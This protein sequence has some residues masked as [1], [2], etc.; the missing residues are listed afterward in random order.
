MCPLALHNDNGGWGQDVVE[1]IAWWEKLTDGKWPMKQANIMHCIC[2]EAF[3]YESTRKEPNNMR[4]FWIANAAEIVK[5]NPKL[6]V[7]VKYLEG[8]KKRVQEYGEKIVPLMKAAAGETLREAREIGL[9]VVESDKNLSGVSDG[10]SFKG[11]V[12]GE[13]C[14]EISLSGIDG[15]YA[16]MNL[17]KE[18]DTK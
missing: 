13:E 10:E 3:M 16:E 1:A 18:K 11:K 5:L 15:G 4:L 2:Q 17:K 7:R 8:W 6:M 9:V 12:N 14:G